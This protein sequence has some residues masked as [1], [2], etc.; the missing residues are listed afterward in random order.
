MSSRPV[1]PDD[2]FQLGAPYER[3]MGRWSR[4]VAPR[5]LDWLAAPAGR[6]WVDVGCGTGVLTEAVLDR[7]AP[8]SVL[9]VDP[10]AG[11]LETA[12]ARLGERARLAEGDAAALPLPAA[13]VDVVVAGLVLN[14]V[15]DPG[16]ALAEWRRV[17][18]PAGLVAAYLW[19][20]GDGM[21]LIRE[22]FDAAV[23]LDP[24]VAELDEGARFRWAKPEPLGR[25]FGEAFG[26]DA[27]VGAIEVVARF[28]DFDDYW[29]PF[30]GGQG[31]A[32][33]YVV[34]LEADHR[35]ALRDLLRRRLPTAH[36]GSITLPLRAWAVA[37]D[38]P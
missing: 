36:D 1:A 33:A 2:R 5:F 7:C 22:F 28:A 21:C 37:V 18:R 11:F 38:A 30:L 23:Q 10:S 8:A 12:R 6:D 35:D 26:V 13:A 24:A 20:Y 16:A 17:V 31:P 19:D 34:G 14:F 9:G 29:Q 32:P 4:L 3:Y 25:L 27:R 15:P